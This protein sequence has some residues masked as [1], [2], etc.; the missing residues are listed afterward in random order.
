MRME[1]GEEGKK[2]FFSSFPLIPHF[3]NFPLSFYRAE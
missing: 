2:D 3:P 1:K